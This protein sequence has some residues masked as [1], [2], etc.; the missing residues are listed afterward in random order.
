MSP[1]ESTTPPTP[2]TPPTSPA[3]PSG[4]RAAFGRGT[5]I[6][7]AIGTLIGAALVYVSVQNSLFAGR[8]NLKISVRINDLD[9]RVGRDLIVPMTGWV[10]Q[11]DL[12]EDLPQSV[13]DTLEI[14]LREERTGATLDITDRLIFE[15]AHGR[16]V[17]PESIRLTTGLFS[18]RVGLTDE[19]EAELVEHRRIRI[20]SWLGGP[21]IGSRQIIHFDF[22][23][24]RDGDGR[25]DFQQDLESFGLASPDQPELAATVARQVAERAVA[26]VL[27][28]YDPKDDPNGTGYTIDTVFVRFLLE[29]ERSP[30]VTRIC[31]GGANDAFPDS[32]G[33]VRFDPQNETK[34]SSECE[35]KDDAPAAGIFPREFAVYS[36]SALYRDVTEPF[37]STR[38]GTPF[39]GLAED[40]ATGAETARGQAIQRAID[41][42]GDALGTIMAHESAHALGLVPPGRPGV[43]LFGG[44]EKDGAEYAHNLDT[45]GKTPETAW[46]MNVGSEFK[47]EDLAGLGPAGELRFRPLNHAY[48][49]DRVALSAGRYQP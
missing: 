23:V 24:D 7:V 14:T 19:N 33:N 49:K 1:P 12:P 4:I 28:A 10:L 15:G 46:L 16:L 35:P 18:I 26:R 22:N 34:G 30:F 41:V 3:S 38:G 6:A 36:Q 2:P 40:T 25:P 39:G 5:V 37:D 13:L 8:H 31:V 32:V 48:L 45:S 20:R 44:S 9:E 27:R 43:G 21:P 29:T 11:V 47:F 42:L 17:L